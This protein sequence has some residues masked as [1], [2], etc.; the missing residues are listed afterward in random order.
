MSKKQYLKRYILIINRLRKSPCSFEALQKKLQQ[1]SALDAENYEISIRTFQRDIKEIAS[2]YHIE[3]GYDRSQNVYEIV[4]DA[5][6]NKTERLMET[7]EIFNALQLSDAL[8]RH[9][10]AE[11]RKPLGTDHLHDLI[12]AIKNNTEVQFSYKKYWEETQNTKSRT[13]QPLSLKEAR[14]RWYLIGLDTADQQIKTFGLDRI[15]PLILTPKKFQRPEDYNPDAIFKHSF[16]I[17][18]PE[19]GPQKI[20]L[21]FSS[22]QAK[23]IQS[24][25]LHASQKIVTDQN[26]ECQV[27]LYLSPTYDFV[28]ELL[29]MGPEVKVLEPE[30]LK[31]EMVLKLHKALQQYQ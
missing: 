17:I 12:H 24:L 19:T 21:S 5:N 14:Y 26:N 31:K 6:E 11:K 29:A 7:F 28:M 27:E 10:Q 22:A 4:Y 15:G 8:Q 16:G 20:V 18:K 30:S 1:E 25:P 2:L 23:Y 9:M 13:I 3:I